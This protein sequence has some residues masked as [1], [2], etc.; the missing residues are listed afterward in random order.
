ML[1]NQTFKQR[2]ADSYDAYAATYGRYIQRL[3][4]PLAQHI[5][6]LAQLKDG[7][8]VLDIGTGSG[9]VAREAAL[10]VAL[11]GYVLGIDLSKGMIRIAKQIDKP[12]E[13]AQITL[14]R[15]G[16]LIYPY[17]AFYVSVVRPAS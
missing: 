11:S 12:P 8:R 3:A 2:D 4:G 10:K 15:G 7:D 6:E 14:N 13:S 16:D 9:L 1:D 17:G 5:C